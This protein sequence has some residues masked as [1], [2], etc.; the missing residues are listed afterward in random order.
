MQWG[1][2][3]WLVIFLRLAL[4]LFPGM[5]CA[6]SSSYESLPFLSFFFSPFQRP[7]TSFTNLPMHVD[8][9]TMTIYR[10]QGYVGRKMQP[11]WFITTGA[12]HF[13]QA[14][15]TIIEGYAAYKHD[16]RS[17]LFA[18][19]TYSYRPCTALCGDWIRTRAT[20]FLLDLYCKLGTV[21]GKEQSKTVYAYDARTK[22]RLWM[23]S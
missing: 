8:I 18:R 12:L 4:K 13:P 21:Q 23:Q 3:S 6:H 16:P 14:K 15:S 2:Q 1:S 10:Y 5:G 7:L 9:I 19:H 22:E 17:F 20:E 11:T